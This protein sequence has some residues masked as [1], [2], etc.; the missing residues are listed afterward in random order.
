MIES[1]RLS[2]GA[3]RN[4]ALHFLAG[5]AYDRVNQSY[6]ETYELF[7]FI[8]ASEVLRMG[9]RLRLQFRPQRLR[10]SDGAAQRLLWGRQRDGRQR[11]L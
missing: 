11:L 3:V 5:V 1:C 10:M 6:G 9:E 2:E 7:S 8:I 4:E